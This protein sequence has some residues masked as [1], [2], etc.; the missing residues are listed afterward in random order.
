MQK[1]DT[2]TRRPRRIGRMLAFSLLLGITLTCATAWLPILFIDQSA[3][4]LSTATPPQRV[5]A[6]VDCIPQAWEVR[7]L[8]FRVRHWLGTSHGQL[9]SAYAGRLT[10]GWPFPAFESYI[11]TTWSWSTPSQPIDF[12]PLTAGFWKIHDLNPWGSSIGINIGPFGFPIRPTWPG[13]ALNVVTYSLLAYPIV[14]MART[15][16]RIHRRRRAICIRCAYPLH[17]L[18]TCPECGTPTHL[19][20]CHSAT[21]PLRHSAPPPLP[22]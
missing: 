6:R 14:T 13:F 20:L 1:A 2:T 21:L 18:P 10:V 15:I 5:Q 17:D 8:G 16:R 22:I 19:P 12:G 4:R 9:D 7:G 3:P 11:G